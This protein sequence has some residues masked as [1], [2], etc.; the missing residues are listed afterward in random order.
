MGGSLRSFVSLEEKIKAV[1]DIHVKR[2]SAKDVVQV[3][4]HNSVDK[5]V[6]KRIGDQLKATGILPWL[7]EWELRPG[8]PWQKALGEQIKS[9]KSAAVFVGFSGFRKSEPDP[10]KQLVWGVTGRRDDPR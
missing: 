9:I 7:D 2:I 6:V 3:R 10:L 5:P 4:R 8:L 1:A